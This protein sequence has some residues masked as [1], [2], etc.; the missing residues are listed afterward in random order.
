[1]TINFKNIP[2]NLRVPLFYAELDASHANT[3][4]ANQRALIIGQI[5]AAGVA[6]PNV[7]L[8]SSGAG[9][10]NTGAAER[11]RSFHDTAR[12]AGIGRIDASANL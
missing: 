7:P 2:Q 8:I 1:M 9:D 6:T 12:I 10:A 3:A 4:I 11:L 5:T